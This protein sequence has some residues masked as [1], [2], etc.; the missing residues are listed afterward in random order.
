MRSKKLR[1]VISCS[2]AFDLHPANGVTL[3]YISYLNLKKLKRQL[4]C[5]YFGSVN[6]REVKVKIHARYVRS[7]LCLHYTVKINYMF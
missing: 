1:G 3:T 2:V 6:W 5:R 7:E 4:K